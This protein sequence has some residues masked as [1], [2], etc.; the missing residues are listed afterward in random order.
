MF[1]SF[2]TVTAMLVDCFA[3]ELDEQHGTPRLPSNFHLNPA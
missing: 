3:P 1:K 2:T